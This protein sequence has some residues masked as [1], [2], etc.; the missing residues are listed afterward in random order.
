MHIQDHLNEDFHTLR[1]FLKDH[2]L[3]VFCWS[4]KD[5]DSINCEDY[6]IELKHL[7]FKVIFEV[8]QGFYSEYD[9]SNSL[10]RENLKIIEKDL[11]DYDDEDEDEVKEQE[12]IEDLIFI[13]RFKGYKLL[14][15]SPQV[16]LDNDDNYK[17]RDAIESVLSLHDYGLLC[18][19]INY[20]EL[21]NEFLSDEEKEF[22]HT[23][24]KTIC[25][26]CYED[27]D[28]DEDEDE[29]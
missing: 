15:V 4:V 21:C 25:E 3:D 13:D 29:G 17:I 26:D 18:D 19:S 20:C 9:S 23:D 6:S 12:R 8:Y 5:Q 10:N 28:E 1:E 7:D 16:D 24:C 11:F 14:L 27:E 22:F 2:K